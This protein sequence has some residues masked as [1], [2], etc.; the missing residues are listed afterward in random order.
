MSRGTP[1]YVAV[2]CTVWV[3]LLEMAALFACVLPSVRESADNLPPPFL[4]C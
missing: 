1:L 2:D 4:A 3:A